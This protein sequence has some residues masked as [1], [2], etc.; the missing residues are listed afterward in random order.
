MEACIRCGLCLEACPTFVLTRLE[1]EGPRGRIAIAKGLLEGHLDLTPDL[2]AHE[3]S[4]LLCEACTQVC[5]AGV[6]VEE[7]GI[8]LRASMADAGA[9][10][11]RERAVGW[12]V[13][14]LGDRRS[15]ERLVRLLGRARRLGLH[16][17]AG[18]LGILRAL[19]LSTHSLPAVPMTF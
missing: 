6:R 14:A 17:V 13:R 5:P 16:R 8:A 4:C 2:V 10:D 18:A 7:L 11:R 1:E 9:L 12:A 19:G 3:M 15:L